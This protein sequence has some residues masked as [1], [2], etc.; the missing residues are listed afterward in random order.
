MIYAHKCDCGHRFEVVKSAKEAT[1]QHVCPKCGDL[2]GR[3]IAGM[4]VSTPPKAMRGRWSR[5]MG[6]HPS[7]IAEQ[8]AALR[9]A[10]CKNVR[11]NDRGDLWV[12]GE[13]ADRSSK[14]EALGLFDP[15]GGLGAPRRKK[16]RPRTW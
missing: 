14:A 3:D 2:A 6:C 5:A 13:G 8:Q 16:D 11:H 9:K 15:N 1:W 7:Q 12:E 4:P 10:G